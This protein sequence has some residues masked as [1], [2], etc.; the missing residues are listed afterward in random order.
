MVMTSER[1]KVALGQNQYLRI[2]YEDENILIVEKPP[3]ILTNYVEGKIRP[4]MAGLV[5]KYLSSTGSQ[6][7]VIAHNNLN[8]MTGGLLVFAKNE[9]AFAAMNLIF[10]NRELS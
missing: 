7:T 10:K 8:F 3:N 6:F 1:R 5:N 2:V 4:T 9:K